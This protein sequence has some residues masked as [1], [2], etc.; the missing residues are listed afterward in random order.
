MKLLIIN[1]GGTSTKIAVY[2]DDK[3]IFKKTV[4]HSADDLGIFPHVFDEY[5][6]RKNLIIE[7]VEEAGFSL[8]DL[9]CVAVLRSEERRVGKECRSRWSPYH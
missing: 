4:I 8:K 2:E 3:E 9:G 7:S 6:Y 1:P 5:E